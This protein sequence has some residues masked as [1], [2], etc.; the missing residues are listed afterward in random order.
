MSEIKIYTGTSGW[1]YKQWQPEFYP[2]G[3]KAADWLE[4]YAGRFKTV[5]VNSSFYKIPAAPMVSRWKQLAPAGFLY[6]IKAWQEIT[7][8][9]QLKNCE[10]E[11]ELMF[12]MLCHFES[13]LAIV[14][15]QLPP[16]L[17]FDEKLLATFIA[18][19][20]RNMNYA[21]EFRHPSWFTP[22]TYAI[23]KN[24]NIAMVLSHQQSWLTPMVRTAGFTYIRLHGASG[25]YIGKYNDEF[26]ERLRLW[27]DKAGAAD[28]F[29]YFN[30]T[31]N[32]IDA[33][34]NALS[35]TGK[36]LEPA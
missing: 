32:G 20:P 7:H 6:S 13:H 15:F 22:K 9:K 16:Y 25:Q 17:Q 11:L 21:F 19:L 12:I 18:R 5:E 8:I 23:L 1:S 29:V 2:A 31:R 33:I 28:N 24:N 27:V 26:V 4:F 35:L 36:V 14:L 34:E 10:A 30:N 3:A